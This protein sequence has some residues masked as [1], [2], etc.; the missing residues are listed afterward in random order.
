MSNGPERLNLALQPLRL[1]PKPSPPRPYTP[2]S[3]SSCPPPHIVRDWNADHTA[4]AGKE[5]EPST[6]DTKKCHADSCMEPKEG[7]NPDDSPWLE[8]PSWEDASANTLHKCAAKCKAAKKPA[9]QF[10]PPDKKGG[11]TW[12]GCLSFVDGHAHGEF[13]KAMNHKT[14]DRS[15]S[16]VI[17]E[18]ELPKGA[19]TKGTCAQWLGRRRGTRMLFSVVDVQASYRYVYCLDQSRPCCLVHC[20]VVCLCQ[21]RT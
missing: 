9:M 15:A 17:C 18:L 2:T 14:T 20:I 5:V 4:G 12:C 7:A 6:P 16:C 3:P 13:D 19:A 10:N 1:L 21:L 11:E 8:G